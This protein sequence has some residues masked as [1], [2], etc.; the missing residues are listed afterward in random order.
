[1]KIA[2]T[3][4]L[5]ISAIM[6]GI[7]LWGGFLAVGAARF[8]FDIRKGVIVYVATI[9]FLLFW[10]VLLAYRRRAIAKKNKSPKD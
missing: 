9:G 5:M 2:Q 10:G 1:M 4:S 3:Q 7:L 6:F 8:D